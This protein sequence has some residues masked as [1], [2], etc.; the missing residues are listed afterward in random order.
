MIRRYSKWSRAQDPTPDRGV[1]GRIAFASGV[2]LVLLQ[3]AQATSV[4][5]T[6]AAT[7]ETLVVMTYNLRSASS[8][9]PVSWATRRSLMRECLR[10]VAP[11][12]MGTQEGYYH[13]LREINSD[14]PEYDWIGQCR[15][16]G[17]QGEFMA[18]FFRRSRFDPLAFD[19]FWLSATPDKIGSKSWGNVPPRMVTWVRFS[20][21]QTGR[22]FYFVTTHVDGNKRAQEQSGRLIRERIKSLTPVAPVLLTGDFNAIPGRDP[23][24]GLLTGDH[25]FSDTWETARKR[26]GD[27][28]STFNGFKALTRNGRRI[29]WILAR[30]NITVDASEIVTFSRDGKYPS[31]HFPVVAWLNIR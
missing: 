4:A 28:V 7:N 29:D 16:G 3:L 19:H 20:D 5:G 26:R 18:V 9:S 24:H 22:E 2:V 11:D 30:G 31:D 21:R 13:Q 10:S 27:G 17:S 1:R 12:L 25:F 6:S 23:L 8:G 14:L 15:D